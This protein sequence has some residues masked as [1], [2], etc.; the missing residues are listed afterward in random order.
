MNHVTTPVVALLSICFLGCGGVKI[1]SRW[2]DRNIAIDGDD[3]DWEGLKLYVRDWPVDIGIANDADFL[4]V[5]L[6][7]SD[8]SLQR[9]VIT[10][11]FEVWVDPDGGRG[12]IL[13]VRY[14]VGMAGRG[15]EGFEGPG[16]RRPGPQ[17]DGGK[18]ISRAGPE[19]MQEAFERMLASQQPV[20]LGKGEQ[21]IRA[22]SMSGEND[23]R[24]MVTYANGRLVYEA[25][26]PLNGQYPL[27]ALPSED[28]KSIGLGFRTRAP[29]RIASQGRGGLGGEGGF[30]GRVG[31]FG[32][33]GFGG[34]GGR[35][36]GRTGAFP[37]SDLTPVEEWT[38][39]TLARAPAD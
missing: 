20:L 19:Q 32:G 29:D 2:P 18:D 39:I 10:R 21:E 28:G 24:V 16:G 3:G 30:G 9:Q 11:G 6:S 36:G 38:R 23:V 15:R 12:R 5:S 8:R 14:P 27:P 22:V 26:F 34:S 25:R 1:D 35:G 31:G 37:N 33:G 7:T 4:Y 17:G 13:G